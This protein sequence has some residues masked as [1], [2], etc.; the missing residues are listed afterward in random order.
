MTSNMAG[1]ESKL[2]EILHQQVADEAFTPSADIPS[3]K[4]EN[5]EFSLAANEKHTDYAQLDLFH[6]AV[7]PSVWE[8]NP[9]RIRFAFKSIQMMFTIIFMV[10]SS[11][12]TLGTLKHLLKI[13]VNAK[14]F[15]G[16]V[17]FVCV[18]SACIIFIDLARHWPPVIRYWTRTEMVFTRPPYEI[19]KNNLARRIRLAALIIIAMSIGEHALYLT[20]AIITYTKRRHICALTDNRTSSVVTFDAYMEENYSYVFQI[21]PYSP[22]IAVYVLVSVRKPCE[23]FPNNTTKPFSFS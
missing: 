16:L 17:F 23:L 19:P 13:G 21:L 11:I 14:N 2:R 10:F 4:E 5:F 20:S 6:R 15:V 9:K 3:T 18:Q 12:L 22:F 7:Y 1:R 8:A